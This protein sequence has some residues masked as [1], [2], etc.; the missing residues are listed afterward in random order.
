MPCKSKI[1]RPIKDKDTDEIICYSLV[2][3]GRCSSCLKSNQTELALR[4]EIDRTSP[5][6]FDSKFITLTYSDDNLIYNYV[7]EESGEIFP[8]PSVTKPEAQKFIKRLRKYLAYDSEKTQLYYYLTGEYGDVTKRPHYHAIIYLIGENT[9]KM[10]L[11]DAVLRSWTKHDL[12]QIRLSK[13][14]QSINSIAAQKYVAKHQVKRCQGSEFQAPFFRLRSKG[15]G[16]EFFQPFNLHRQQFLIDNHYLVYDRNKKARAPRFYCEKLGIQSDY[17]TISTYTYNELNKMYV[18][19]NT[20]IKN[21]QR[22]FP[23]WSLSKISNYLVCKKQQLQEYDKKYYDIM[24]KN[25][26]SSKKI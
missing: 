10:T 5:R 21:I 16:S 4:L 8:L 24:Y 14:I 20:E 1:L 7:D 13:V 23:T 3:C 15:I 12:S 9:C 19:L 26:S 22:R 17:S 11:V 6:C 2:P 18:N 25:L